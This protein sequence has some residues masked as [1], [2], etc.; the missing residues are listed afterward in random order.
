MEDKKTSEDGD[1][2]DQNRDGTG[3]AQDNQNLKVIDEGY[4]DNSS[5]LQNQ[6]ENEKNEGA[7]EEA[8]KDLKIDETKQQEG[9]QFALAQRSSVNKKII[10][11]LEA[12]MKA[13][14]KMKIDE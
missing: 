5:K 11:E 7:G 2:T 3:D 12:S 14:K 9:N 4:E 6:K 8:N 13:I 10:K 1:K